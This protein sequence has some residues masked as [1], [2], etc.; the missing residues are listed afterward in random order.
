ML[1][2]TPP[3]KNDAGNKVSANLRFYLA[4]AIY[5][6]ERAR[7]TPDSKM[8]F[9]SIHCDKLFYKLRGTMIYVPGRRY[10]HPKYTPKNPSIYKQY[11][12][13]RNFL[14]MHISPSTFGRDEALSHNF[15]S[16]LVASL[17][18]HRVPLKVHGTGDPIR[19]VIRQSGG[20]AYNAAV[21]NYTL[22][23]TKVLVETANLGNATDRLRLADPQWRQWFA[24]AFVEA[25]KKHFKAAQ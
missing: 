4:N 3:H 24:E 6:K 1:L 7:G 23:P 17:R 12:E 20:R 11:A 19:N 21:L 22:I 5:R 18:N 13:S 9:A 25:V 8:L 2:T 16:T 15:A 14:T 10:R